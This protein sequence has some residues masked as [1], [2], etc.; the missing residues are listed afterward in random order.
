MAKGNGSAKAVKAV[1]ETPKKVM[2]AEAPSKVD[3]SEMRKLFTKILAANKGALTLVENKHGAIQIRDAR[4]LLFSARSNGKMIITHPIM[5]GKNRVFKHPGDKWD[6]FSEVPFESV[7][8][9]MLEN[10]VKDQK[11]GKDYF[12]QFY[13]KRLEESGLYQKAEAAKARLAKLEKEVKGQKKAV[14]TSLKEVKKVKEAKTPGKVSAKAIR[15]V[16]V[17]A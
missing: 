15:A 8:L 2:K 13:G 3:Y 11:S 17:K 1:V 16:A 6:H 14:K 7:T 12:N 4:G 9:K 5:D 10:R